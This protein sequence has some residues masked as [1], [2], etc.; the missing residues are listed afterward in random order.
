MAIAMGVVVIVGCSAT[1]AEGEAPGS[2]ALTAAP[3]PQG[4][5]LAC[6]AN[7]ADGASV[8][9]SVLLFS[10]DDDEGTIQVDRVL[11][12]GREGQLACTVPNPMALGPH[13]MGSLLTAN[14][15][16]CLPQ[17]PGGGGGKVRFVV[18]WSRDKKGRGPG[19][20]L[21][22][23]SEITTTDSAGLVLAKIARDCKAITLPPDKCAGVTC[24][25]ET[26]CGQQAPCEVC[27]EGK[28]VVNAPHFDASCAPS[29]GSASALC[30]FSGICGATNGQCSPVPTWDCQTCCSQ[31]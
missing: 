15:A 11:V 28:C 25:T 22:G 26:I 14:L 18:Y 17:G 19:N 2:A 30:G 3:T 4:G 9:R 16:W 7:H 24:R 5:I 1:A 13:Q 10:N 31:F 29:C 8:I 23:W 20:P 21:D 12:Y 27:V 6:S